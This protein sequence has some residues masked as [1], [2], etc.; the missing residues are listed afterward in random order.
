M[1]YS[2]FIF[3]LF[4]VTAFSTEY[5]N[6]EFNVIVP[7]ERGGST[8]RMAR[9]M[10]P[11]LEEEMTYKVNVV[12]RKGQ[13][14]LL[15]TID[16]LKSPQDG[17]NLFASTLSPYILNTILI[18]KAPYN[19]DDFEIINLQWFD[20]E[21]IAVNQYSPYSTLEELIQGIKTAKEPIKVAMLYQSTG[22][23]IIKLLMK[24]LG[25]AKDKIKFVFF[26]GGKVAREALIDNSVDI[27]VISAQG[28]EKYRKFLKPI[29]IIKEKRSKRWDAP[30]LNEALEST[31]IS[32]PIFHGSMRGFAVSKEFKRNYPSRYNYILKSLKKVLARKKVQL[33]LR[34][35]SIGCSWLGP[36]KSNKLLKETMKL[37]KEYDYLYKD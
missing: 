37:L 1:K 14:T 15:G 13:G 22:Y 19:L 35:N 34:R 11:F 26:H 25:I 24:K 4:H 28:S 2:I 8:D 5:P 9:A 31:N 21:F 33:N 23:L 30:T 18:N 12:N 27:I 3:L 7:L 17:Y 32:L 29:V 20:Y 6:K 10:Q 36:E 16:F